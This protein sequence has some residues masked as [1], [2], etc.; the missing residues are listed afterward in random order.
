MKL[1]LIFSILLLSL[2]LNTAAQAANQTCFIQAFDGHYLTAVNGGGET[3][4]AIHTNATT[5]ST[6]ETFTL[7]P[8]IRGGGYAIKTVRGFYLTAVGGGGRATDVVHTDATVPSRWERFNLIS[9]GNHVFAI[10]TYTRNYLTAQDSGGR[11]T[12]V[13]HSNAV[14]ISTWEQFRFTCH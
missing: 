12:D 13:I 3:V 10:Q 2:G 8:F 9:L 14:R 11:T 4:D 5:P 6:W 1:S 7:V